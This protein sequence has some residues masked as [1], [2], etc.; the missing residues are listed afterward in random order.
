MPFRQDRG[1]IRAANLLREHYA[2]VETDQGHCIAALGGDGF[3][4][5]RLHEIT[6]NSGQS[7][8]PIFGMN[9]GTRWFPMNAFL[10][11]GRKA[12]WSASRTPKHRK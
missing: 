6:K 7:Q 10:R 3:M 1:F 12:C 9:F 4:L 5:S 8:V 2:E 11:F